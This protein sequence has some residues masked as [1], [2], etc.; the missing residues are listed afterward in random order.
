MRTS[1]SVLREIWRDYGAQSGRR[2]RSQ[3]AIAE[4]LGIGPSQLAQWMMDP[5]PRA[6]PLGVVGPLCRVLGASSTQQMR[7]MRARLRE[8]KDTPEGIAYALGKADAQRAAALPPSLDQALRRADPRFVLW[9]IDAKRAAR[10]LQ[11][12]ARGA[13]DRHLAELQ[14]DPLSDPAQRRARCER[15]QAKVRAQRPPFADLDARQRVADRVRSEIPRA[16]RRRV[17]KT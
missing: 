3:Q 12:W 1:G 2:G 11:A 17:V 9:E 16:R 10:E 8:L 7:L 13:T 15:L 5:P 6:I 4:R 14:A